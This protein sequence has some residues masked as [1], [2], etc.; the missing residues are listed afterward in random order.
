[1]HS[2][3][4]SPPPKNQQPPLQP[5]PQTTTTITGSSNKFQI[6]KP[7]KKKKKDS[8][9]STKPQPNR[10]IND[11]TQPT[12]GSEISN[13]SCGGRRAKISDCPWASKASNRR[14]EVQIGELQS[15]SSASNQ[16]RLFLRD[17]KRKRVRKKR[18]R[19]RERERGVE[20]IIP[21]CRREEE[22][23]R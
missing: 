15:A 7:Q 18:E 12:I 14:V 10:S 6:Q 19:E 22:S 2:Q 23:E 1:M 11:Q 13:E 3:W 5:L 4:Q 17:R 16:N 8:K 20:T 21:K 9:S